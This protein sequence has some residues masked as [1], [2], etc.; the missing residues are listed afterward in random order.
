MQPQVE[1]GHIRIKIN[2]LIYQTKR[3]YFLDREG[4][5]FWIAKR[6][7]KLNKENMTVDIEEWLYNNLFGT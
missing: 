2:E 4:D 5:R 7:C 3:S 6:Y 1:D